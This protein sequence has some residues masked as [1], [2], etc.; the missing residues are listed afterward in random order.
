MVINRLGINKFDSA[1]YK[2]YLFFVVSILFSVSSPLLAADN[3]SLRQAKGD[4]TTARNDKEMEELIAE[5]ENRGLKLGD[6]DPEA[7][8]SEEDRE[9]R[10]EEWHG[11]KRQRPLGL[12][13]RKLFYA[14]NYKNLSRVREALVEGAGEREK[15]ASVIRPRH[16]VIFRLGGPFFHALEKRCDDEIMKELVLARQAEKGVILYREYGDTQC[17]LLNSIDFY[18]DNPNVRFCE[19]VRILINAGSLSVEKLKVN[20]PRTSFIGRIAQRYL[21]ACDSLAENKLSQDEMNTITRNYVGVLSILVELGYKDAVK[22]AFEKMKLADL[23]LAT[24]RD[25]LMSYLR[26]H[27]EANKALLE[28]CEQATAQSAAVTQDEMQYF[29]VPSYLTPWVGVVSAVA[30]VALVL[31]GVWWKLPQNNR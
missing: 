22:C 2:F 7:N 8:E 31:G 27:K 10:M 15:Y 6:L 18:M 28:L 11:A 12:A 17:N 3:N 25:P 4:N 24:T 13:N 1:L 16:T 5:R 14:I 20:D 29:G 19:T 26:D 9:L 30:I 21:N 23:T